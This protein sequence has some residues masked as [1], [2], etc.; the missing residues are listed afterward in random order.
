MSVELR[1]LQHFVS[2]AEEG[3]FTRAARRLSYVQSALSVSIKALECELGVQLFDRTTHRVVLTDAGEA[4]LPV[5]RRT[6]ASADETLDMAAAVKGVLRGRLRVSGPLPV[7]FVDIPGL[8]GRFHRLHPDVEIQIGSAAGG[9][10]DVIEQLRQGT[11]DI[12]FVGLPDVGAGVATTPLGSED[13]VLVAAPDL[14]P[15]GREPIPLDTL[16]SAN[17]VDFPPGWGVRTVIDRYFATAGLH[18]QVTIEVPD[19]GTLLHLVRAGLGI[20]LLPPSLLRSS[21]VHLK[22]FLV[23]PTITRHFAMAMPSGSG[24]NAAARALADMVIQSIDP[25]A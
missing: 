20:S 16:T 6:L 5:A 8:L 4:I 17:F 23:T 1:Q 22:R 15:P 3:S 12:G 21:D 18:R 2:V 25:G 14:A 9:T 10:A 13:L 19:T 24:R 7:T 11:I